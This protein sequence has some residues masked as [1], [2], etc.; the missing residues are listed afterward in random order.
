MSY[1]SELHV[2][3][4]EEGRAGV[5]AQLVRDLSSTGTPYAQARTDARQLMARKP[6]TR[7]ELDASPVFDMHPVAHPVAHRLNLT[8]M[9]AGTL[10]EIVKDHLRPG[11][12]AQRIAAATGYAVE[13]VQVV[14]EEIGNEPPAR[15]Q[16][17]QLPP[18]HTATLNGHEYGVRELRMDHSASRTNKYHL[19]VTRD[20]QHART[21][22]LIVKGETFSVKG[23]GTAHTMQGAYTLAIQGAAA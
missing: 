12:T 3:Q 16:P 9:K 11:V 4:Q 14:M 20:G 10:V 19:I 15:T 5:Y 6:A 1:H 18:D 22:L 8:P 21:Y 13:A 23:L 7:A 2:T 17:A